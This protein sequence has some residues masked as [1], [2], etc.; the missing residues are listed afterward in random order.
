MLNGV[1]V[2][3]YKHIL[4]NGMFKVELIILARL[5]FW[6]FWVEFFGPLSGLARF[7]FALASQN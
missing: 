5:A 7:F 6:A 1:L 2:I 3:T 4:L